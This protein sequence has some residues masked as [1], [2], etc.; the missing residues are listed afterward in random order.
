MIMLP[1]RSVGSVYF[2]FADN[3]ARRSIT[4]GLADI[5]MFSLMILISYRD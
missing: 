3:A 2:K 5:D 4:V 1:I